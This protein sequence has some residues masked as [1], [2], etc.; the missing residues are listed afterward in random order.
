ML[1]FITVVEE[2]SWSIWCIGFENCDKHQSCLNCIL[3]VID[4]HSYLRFSCIGNRDL[5]SSQQN[6]NNEGLR[7]KVS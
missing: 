4:E 1:V 3:C 5:I 7:I 2:G 6:G